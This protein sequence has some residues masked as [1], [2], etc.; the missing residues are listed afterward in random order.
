MRIVTDREI[1]TPT[2]VALVDRVVANPSLTTMAG[3]A[4]PCG[5]TALKPVFHPI[6][7]P[8]ATFP[9]TSLAVRV[10]TGAS[11]SIGLAIYAYVV[12]GAGTYTATLIGQLNASLSG[13]SA[14]VIQGD[15]TTGAAASGAVS[16]RGVRSG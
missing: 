5:V 6:K 12:T 15:V 10:S 4:Q 3:G 13:A 7:P 8:A 11:S 1:I 16:G 9:V 14:G 2:G